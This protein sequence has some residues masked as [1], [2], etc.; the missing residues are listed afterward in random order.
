MGPSSCVR[1][2]VL[3]SLFLTI[4][5]A[6]ARAQ[7]AAPPPPPTHEATGEIAFIGTTGNSSTSA[8]GVNGEDIA[9]PTNW[10]IKNRVSFIR[11]ES[12]GTTTAESFFYLFRGERT[13]TKR[14]ASFGE[15]GYFRDRFAGVAN[16]NTINGGLSIRLIDTVLQTLSADV[17]LGY[18]NE[19]RL[20]GADISSATYSFGGSYRLHISPT[21]TLDEDARLIGTFDRAEDWRLAQILSLTAQLTSLLSLKVSNTLRYSNFPAPTFQKTDTTTSIALVAKF[22][23]Q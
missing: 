13:L 5:P 2:V 21:A 10:M 17:A 22:K 11:N 7:A 23:R 14:L 20:T 18:L 15:Y 4:L 9:R 1:N 3:S 6:L 8:F 16:R 19:D 12:D